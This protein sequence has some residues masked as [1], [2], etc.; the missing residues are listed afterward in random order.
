MGKNL[1]AWRSMSPEEREA[2]LE[3]AAKPKLRR[4]S[5]SITPR[6]PDAVDNFEEPGRLAVSPAQ[7]AWR[8]RMDAKF[9]L[10][11]I[12]NRSRAA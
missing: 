1:D 5:R 9:G 7:A 10:T 3:A 8:A 2:A 4:Q 12:A 11:T 6:S